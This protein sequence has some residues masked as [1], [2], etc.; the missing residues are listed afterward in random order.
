[1]PVLTRIGE[2]FA[3]RVAASVLSAIQLPDLIATTAESYEQVAIDLAMHPEK[4]SDVRRR[5]T[6]NRHATPFFDTVSF[7]RD[8]ESAYRTMHRRHREGPAKEDIVVSN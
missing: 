1:M 6:N 4:L 5:L 3:G 2:T 7:T 8:I